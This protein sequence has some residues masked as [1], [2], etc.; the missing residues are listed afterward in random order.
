LSRTR[1]KKIAKGPMRLFKGKKKVG[2]K[3]KP[4]DV[5]SHNN[6]VD[7]KGRLRAQDQLPMA[8]EAKANRA[9]RHKNSDEECM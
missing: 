1:W 6:N 3:K 5:S 2:V 8:V 9:A 4:M 7:Q